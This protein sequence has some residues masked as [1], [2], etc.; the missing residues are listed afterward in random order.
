MDEWNNKNLKIG[1]FSSIWEKLGAK[2]TKVLCQNKIG[3]SGQ[4]AFKTEQIVANLF[5]RSSG[6][7][8]L[9][10]CSGNSCSKAWL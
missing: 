9:Q 1:G 6:Q 2:Y 7:K 4:F 3:T 5:K 10:N 8:Q